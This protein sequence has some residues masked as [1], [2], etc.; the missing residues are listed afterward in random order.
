[1]EGAVCVDHMHLCLS[2]PP[3]L[4]VSEFMGYLKRKSALM[5]FINIPNREVNGTDRFG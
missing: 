3:K 4:C 2:I 5:I 1:M